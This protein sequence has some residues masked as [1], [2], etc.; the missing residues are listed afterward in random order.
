MLS[1][2]VYPQQ[3]ALVLHDSSL[4]LNLGSRPQMFA[5]TLGLLLGAPLGDA[6]GL[7]V[8]LADGEAL[9]AEEGVALGVPEGAG[10]GAAVAK[11][12]PVGP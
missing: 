2:P 6:L 12:I 7:P 9:G 3:S 8:G 5:I 1:S 4:Y 11:H 10:V